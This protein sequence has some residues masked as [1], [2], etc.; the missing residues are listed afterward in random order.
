MAVH[1]S[2]SRMWE[3]LVGRS[4]PFW[5]FFYPRFQAAFPAQVGEV[6]LAT[7]YRALNKVRPSLIRVQ[8]DEATY[9]L[10]IMLRLEIEIALFEGKLEVKDLPAAWNQKMQAYLGVL[11]PNDALGVLQDVHWSGGSFGYF[12]TYA[13]GNLVS[14]QLWEVIHKDLPELDAQIAQGSFKPLLDW[15]RANVHQ[16]GA[17]YEPQ[18]LVQKITGSRIDPGAYL[19]Y[20]LSKYGEIYHL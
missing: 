15:L 20:L 8:A 13:L 16:Y 2:Q 14:A 6:D 1:E 18:E 9:N 7:F 10:H 5:R 17:R 3:N 12:P 19:R 11:P 4:L